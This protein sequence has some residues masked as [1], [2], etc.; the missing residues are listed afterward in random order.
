[1]SVVKG[2]RVLLSVSVSPEVVEVAKSIAKKEYWPLSR[3]VEEALREYIERHGSGNPSISL[4]E[5]FDRR[6]IMALPTLG[7]D[8]DRWPWKDTPDDLLGKIREAA[9]KWLRA[10]ELEL[11]KRRGG[12]IEF[13]TV[14]IP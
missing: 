12:V 4:D 6:V 7:H 14:R 5:F 9:E 8:P 3:V 11:Q 10:S 1:M 13:K 2:R